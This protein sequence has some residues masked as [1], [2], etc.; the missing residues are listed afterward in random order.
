MPSLGDTQYPHRELPQ[1]APCR[2]WVTAMGEQPAQPPSQ[3]ATLTMDHVHNMGP[4]TKAI[5][6]WG[7]GDV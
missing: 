5:R 3:E 7:Q 2:S 4:L 6:G 1:V